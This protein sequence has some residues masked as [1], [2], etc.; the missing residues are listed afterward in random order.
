MVLF[1]S[2][3]Y[4]INVVG[5]GYT[6]QSVAYGFLIFSL[7][8]LKNQKNLFF[9]LL[10]LLGALFHKSLILFLILYLIN[11]KKVTIKE[12]IP[13]IF[14]IVIVSSVILYRFDTIQFYIYYYLGDGQ[15]LESKGTILRYL[16]NLIPALIIILFYKKLTCSN[17]E[18]K[19]IFYFHYLQSVVSHCFNSHQQHLIELDYT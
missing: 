7:F 11:I 15:H 12:F 17:S 13:F 6:R 14:L 4:I 5:M 9:L 19:F 16:I 2:V 18:K 10:I 8:A 1:V 3:P